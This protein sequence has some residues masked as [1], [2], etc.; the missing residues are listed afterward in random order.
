[1]NFITRNTVPI[2]KRNFSYAGVRKF[3]GIE[4]DVLKEEIEAYRARGL[5]PTNEGGGIN[6]AFVEYLR[7]KHKKP[8]G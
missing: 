6:G 7:R 3:I 1:M 2:E 8:L 4:Q 5:E